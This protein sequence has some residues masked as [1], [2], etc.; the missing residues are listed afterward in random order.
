[1][2]IQQFPGSR[3]RTNFELTIHDYI[4]SHLFQNLGSLDL[5]PLY[6]PISIR[7]IQSTNLDSISNSE[8]THQSPVF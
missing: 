3:L 5:H 2:S 4:I 7:R 8:L 6:D 1:M